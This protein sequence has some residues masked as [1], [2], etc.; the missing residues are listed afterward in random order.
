MAE[1]KKKTGAGKQKMAAP[2]I[3][4]AEARR[5]VLK[6]TPLTAEEREKMKRLPLPPS[7]YIGDLL[8]KGGD[9]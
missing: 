2:G 9:Y 5:L 7:Y 3:T 1:K 4:M 8:P 6:K